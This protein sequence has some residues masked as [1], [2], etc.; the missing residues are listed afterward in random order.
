M[1]L[2]YVYIFL[3]YEGVQREEKRIEE[4]RGYSTQKMSLCYAPYIFSSVASTMKLIHVVTVGP[5]IF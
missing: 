2:N 4:K 3:N 5:Y 1:N